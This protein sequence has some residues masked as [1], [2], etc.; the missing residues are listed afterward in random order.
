MEWGGDGARQGWGR[1]PPV[2]L[3]CAEGG[4]RAV[5]G[6]SKGSVEGLGRGVCTAPG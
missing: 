6:G 4:L 2:R 3:Q 1:Q 5:V